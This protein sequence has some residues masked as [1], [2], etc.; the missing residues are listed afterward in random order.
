MG[1]LQ[2]LQTGSILPTGVFYLWIVSLNMSHS[3]TGAN[4]RMHINLILLLQKQ[5]NQKK[6]SDMATWTIF[7]HNGW[8][9]WRLTSCLD[10][11]CTLQFLVVHGSQTPYA[12]RSQKHWVA[13]PTI[14]EDQSYMAFES[15]LTL[16]TYLE[17]QN[18]VCYSNKDKQ[19]ISR[20]KW[21]LDF[22]STLYVHDF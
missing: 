13:I 18:V 8:N 9:C 7:P 20:D 2:M 6:K 22:F 15:S 21:S 5:T 16:V 14:K 17:C 1:L 12:A 19:P 4:Q 10:G 11:I 3:P